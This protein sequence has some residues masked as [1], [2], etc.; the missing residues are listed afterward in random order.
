MVGLPCALLARIGFWSSSTK[1][2]GLQGV[3]FAY[4]QSAGEE[5]PH[6][7]A[8]QDGIACAAGIAAASRS[9]HARVYADAQKAELGTA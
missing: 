8:L 7:A 4:I 3:R 2:Y 9:L 6:C 1:F 5:G